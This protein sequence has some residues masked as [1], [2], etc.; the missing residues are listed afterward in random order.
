MFILYTPKLALFF[1][2][3][4]LC[5]VPESAIARPKAVAIFCV[6]NRNNHKLQF[7]NRKLPIPVFFILSPFNISQ[8]SIVNSQLDIYY[9]IKI[10]KYK[11]NF[12]KIS[13]TSFVL[14]VEC[15]VLRDMIGGASRHPT[16]MKILSSEQIPNMGRKPV[17]F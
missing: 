13:V 9:T 7:I 17:M 10:V 3:S 1:Q 15:F 11:V 14:R 8:S 4:V 16:F 12:Q 2:I 5:K 6:V